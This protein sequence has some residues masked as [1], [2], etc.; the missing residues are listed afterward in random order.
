MVPNHSEDSQRILRMAGSLLSYPVAA[1]S[2]V[3]VLQVSGQLN[4]LPLKASFP[5]L[6]CIMASTTS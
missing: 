2:H 1:F 6:S 5:Q 4:F 3:H